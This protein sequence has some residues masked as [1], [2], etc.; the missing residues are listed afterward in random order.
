MPAFKALSYSSTVSIYI[1]IV[2]GGYV[3][4]TGSGLACPDWPLCNGGIIPELS[5]P[6]IIEYTHRLV[7]VLVTILVVSTAATVW[8]GLRSAKAV[9]SASTLTIVL[10]LA[11]I[12]LGMVTVATELQ[13]HVVTA[14]LSL[15]VALFASSLFVSLQVHLLSLGQGKT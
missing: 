14:H 9:L 6:V 5:A 7:T 2:I 15:A 11:Q 10:L 3:S 1:L 13:P 4:A 8:R 12:L